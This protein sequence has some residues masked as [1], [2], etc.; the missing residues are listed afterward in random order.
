MKRILIVEDDEVSRHLLQGI[1]KENAVCDEAHNGIQGWKLYNKSLKQTK[2]DLM[3]LDVEMPKMD[4]LRLIT[5]IRELERFEGVE[6][7]RELPV[8]VVTGHKD[9]IKEAM[10]AGCNDFLLKPICTEELLHRV[11][12]FL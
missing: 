9:K 4:G 5:L 11:S 6:K 7:G 3:L 2:Y 12:R 8:V 1:L 10:A